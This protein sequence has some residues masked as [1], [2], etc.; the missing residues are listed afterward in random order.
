MADPRPGPSLALLCESCRRLESVR[1]EATGIGSCPN[2]GE[3]VRADRPRTV[4]GRDFPATVLS[5]PIPVLVDFYADWCGPCDWIVP[6]LEEVAKD[7]AGALLVVKV[8]VEEAPELA[9]THRIASVPIVALFI[10]G[11]EVDR[12]IG[13]EPERVRRLASAHEHRAE[14][15][16]TGSD[17][18]E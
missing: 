10:G 4:R 8:D 11:K 16:R 5:S 6:T 1:L 12:S 3:V 7:R 14:V 17:H 13:V 9:T 18:P 15:D 2:C